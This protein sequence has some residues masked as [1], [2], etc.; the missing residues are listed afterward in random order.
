VTGKGRRLR[1]GYEVRAI[2][3]RIMDKLR[4]LSVAPCPT[5]PQICR[6]VIRREQLLDEIHH[7]DGRVAVRGDLLDEQVDHL[8]PDIDALPLLAISASCDVL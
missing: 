5:R 6:D 7:G 8:A 4:Y 1:A 2:N 3:R